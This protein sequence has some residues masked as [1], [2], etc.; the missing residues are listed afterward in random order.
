MALW[1]KKKNKFTQFFTPYYDELTLFV[2]SLVVLLFI[3]TNAPS[4]LL[5]NYLAKPLIL[6]GSAT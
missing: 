1:M 6:L 4:R 5:K 3:L 2:M